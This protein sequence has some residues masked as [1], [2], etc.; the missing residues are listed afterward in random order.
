MAFTDTDLD[1]YVRRYPLADSAVAL[2][3]QTAKSVSRDVGTTTYPSV[4]TEMQSAKMGVSVNTESRTGELAYALH[5][6]FDDRVLALYEQL[7]P[8][9]CQRINR[10]GVSV[11]RSYCA[12]FLVLHEE[13]PFVVG[14]KTEDKANEKIEKHPADWIRRNGRVVDLPA[15]R[16][17]AEIGLPHYVVLSTDLPQIRVSNLRMLLKVRSLTSGVE[18]VLEKAIL[19]QLEGPSVIKISDLMA[20]LD[21]KDMTPLLRLILAR[22][23][24]ARLDDQLLSQPE[25]CWIS[26]HAVLLQQI[27]MCS[28]LTDKND[29]ATVCIDDVPRKVDAEESLRR[30]DL[31]KE[32]ARMRS[33]QRW[34]AAIRAEKGKSQ[35]QALLPKTALRG[36]RLPKRPSHVLEFAKASMLQNWASPT[37]ISLHNAYATYRTDAK[38]EHP[39]MAPI[40]RTAFYTLAKVVR[41][42][43]SKGRGGLRE[44]NADSPPSNVKDRALPPTR[45]FEMGS[46]DHSLAK[47]YCIVL[48]TPDFAYVAR[49]WLTVLRDVYTGEPLARW[50]SFSKP[51]RRSVAMVIRHCVRRHG[52]LPETILCDRGSDFRSVYLSSLCA[53]LGVDL[54]FHPTAHSRYGS[55]IE[56]FFG[57]F[58]TRWLDMRPGNR[59]DV[60]SLRFIS[61][62]HHPRKF[63]CL[64]LYDLF[65]E[66]DDFSDWFTTVE[67]G[68]KGCTPESLRREGLAHF[69]FSGVKVDYDAAFVIATA[70]DVKEAISV[71]PS[72]GIKICDH[73]YWN[74]AL[75]GLSG[76]K[77]NADVRIDP[78][79]YSRIYAR[80]GHSWVTCLSTQS[81]LLASTDTL[82][83]AS[84]SILMIDGRKVLNRA[85]DDAGEELIE[86][87]RRADA[88][89]LDPPSTETDTEPSEPDVADLWA[90]AR[91][92][93]VHSFITSQWG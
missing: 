73:H 90:Q 3:H 86:L 12:D 77:Q 25:S 74:P 54:S 20:S 43:A 56:R 7:P 39:R 66:F 34:R 9:D 68:T 16:A 89:Y 17:F 50:I 88:R 27:T 67:P 28:A 45:P 85:K 29:L 41:R 92:Q 21:M 91:E 72:R 8:V 84:A 75:G 81:R 69:P 55:D 18:E 14:V 32:G 33:A 23:V 1:T 5:L 24:F 61:G 38:K 49:P 42:D 37:R 6:E 22:K 4:V 62:T 58:K 53:H 82:A 76:R 31:L 40:S 83:R 48:Q 30:I 26:A 10:H 80:V 35:F 65:R 71:D 44:A 60:K 52:R 78:E 19:Q 2:I 93:H 63:A 79:D 13:G 64:K 70:V 47:I 87:M 59:T 11:L 51:S 46:V 57:I 36:N 15:E